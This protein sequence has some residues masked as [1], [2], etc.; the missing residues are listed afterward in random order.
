MKKINNH[1]IIYQ[2]DKGGKG[3][4]AIADEDV[5]LTQRQLAGDLQYLSGK[6]FHAHLEHL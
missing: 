5:W 6:Y 1:L 2:D 4:R 3:E